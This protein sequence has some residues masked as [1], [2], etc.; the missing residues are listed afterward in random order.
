MA[1]RV[2]AVSGA[3]AGVKEPVTEAEMAKPFARARAADAGEILAG[4]WDLWEGWDG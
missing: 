4:E 1:E 3:L 2:K